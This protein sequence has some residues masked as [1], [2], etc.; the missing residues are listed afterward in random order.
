MVV[1]LTDKACFLCQVGTCV[2]TYDDIHHTL[3]HEPNWRKDGIEIQIELS[4]GEKL[5][6]DLI[7]AFTLTVH[8]VIRKPDALYGLD[9]CKYEN[10]SD[11]IR[12]RLN[13]KLSAQQY[14]ILELFHE[15]GLLP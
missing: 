8:N 9:Y 4:D 1:N 2:V 7:D 13:N 3:K 5:S 6:T 14:Y 10:F 12:D 15:S 11:V